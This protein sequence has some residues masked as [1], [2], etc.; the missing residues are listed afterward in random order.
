MT[1]SWGGTSLPA[2]SEIKIYDEWI[3]QQYV[4]AS[5]AMVSD[6][7]ATKKV[8]LLTWK[9]VTTAEKDTLYGKATT[10]ASANLILPDGVTYAVTPLRKTFNAEAVGITPHW[11]VRLAVRET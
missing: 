1:T 5:G 3:G 7:L 8:L 11:I 9:G 6:G 2:P 4:V 10:L